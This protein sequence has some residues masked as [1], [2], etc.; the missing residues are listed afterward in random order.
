MPG[1]ETET[2]VVT[3]SQCG[4]SG[5]CPSCGGSGSNCGR[6]YSSGRCQRCGGSGKEVILR[7]AP[8]G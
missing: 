7:R 6:C 2:V 3:C 5:R 1:P 8:Y 4:G